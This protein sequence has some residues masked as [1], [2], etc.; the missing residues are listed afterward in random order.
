MDLFR[1]FLVSSVFRLI[2]IESCSA[3][4]FTIFRLNVWNSLPPSEWSSE[5]TGGRNHKQDP[6]ELN[7][8]VKKRVWR[9]WRFPTGRQTR[10]ESGLNSS[11]QPWRLWHPSSPQRPNRNSLDWHQER[12]T[13]PAS[14]PRPDLNAIGLVIN[15][16]VS[17]QRDVPASVIDYS[18][19]QITSVLTGME[20]TSGRQRENRIKAPLSQRADIFNKYEKKKKEILSWILHLGRRSVTFTTTTEFMTFNSNTI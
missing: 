3:E 18:S 20:K 14:A 9:R 8:K 12:R 19:S 11:L 7:R 1:L 10:T 6:E 2:L 15:S 5:N 4:I 17:G 13:E 16:K